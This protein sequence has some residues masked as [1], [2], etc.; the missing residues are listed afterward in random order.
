MKKSENVIVN[1]DEREN[2]KNIVQYG[3]V[4][5]KTNF[6]AVEPNHKTCYRNQI[7]S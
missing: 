7:E 6:G 1:N 5:F 3:W 4:R 2:V